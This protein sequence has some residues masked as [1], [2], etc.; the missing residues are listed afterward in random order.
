MTEARR[1]GR[2]GALVA[3]VVTILGLHLITPR[4]D[5]DQAVTGLMGWH[6]LQGEFPIFF[7]SQ[8]H[9]GV[10]EAY[11]A[12]VTF[13]LF[14]LSRAA[15][16]LVPALAALGLVLLVYRTGALLFGH[17]AG[18][19]GMLFATIVSPYVAAHY[20]RARAYYV[21]HLLLGQV[22]LCAAALWLVR[23]RGPSPL[24]QA[25]RT[26]LLVVMGLAGGL[27]LYCGF[28]IVD[29]LIPALLV[30]LLTDPRLPLRPGAWLGVLAFLVGSLPFWLYN[31][32]HDWATFVVGQRFQAATSTAEA[33]RHL[34]AQLLPILLG[35]KPW[36]DTPPF[37]PWPLALVVPVTAA[38]AVLWL[39]LRA[40]TALPRIGR[41]PERAGEAFLVVAAA[42]AVGVVWYG[43]YIQVPRYL[44]PLSPVLALVLARFVQL[45]GRRSRLVAAI[46]ALAYLGVVGVGMVGDVTIL[47]P[48]QWAAYWGERREDDRLFAFLREQGITHAYSF[49]YWLAPRLTF[50]AGERPVVAQPFSDRYPPYTRAV[51]D[52][53]R[54]AYILRVDAERVARWLRG[55]EATARRQDVG[56]YTVFWDF[57]APPAAVALP[58]AGWRL[59]TTAGRGEAAEL[60]DGQLHSGWASA[61]GPAG[62][63]SV[64]VD[65]GQ[66]A[67][68]SGVTVISTRP[69]HGPDHL[70]VAA[71]LGRGT[72]DP[73][74][75]IEVGGL[76]VVWQNGALRAAPGRTLTVR[77]PPVR[78]RR[79]SLTDLGPGGTWSVGELFL[80]GPPGLRPRPATAD[81]VATVESL[82]AEGRRLERAGN[83]AAALGRYRLAM[84]RGPDVPDGYAEFARLGADVP[85]RAGSAAAQAAWFAEAGLVEEARDRYSAIAAS[86][87]ADRLDAD[88]ARR[89]AALAVQAGDRPEATRLLAEA[90]RVETPTHRV[91][92]V[93]GRVV[94][95]VG[96]DL[97]SETLRAG[98]T[99]ELGYHWRFHGQTREPLSAYVHFRIGGGRTR[100]E[101]DH[102]LPAPVPGF[103]IPQSVLERRWVTI[104]ADAEPGR[105]RLV[106]GVWNPQTGGRLRRWW[107]GLVP[108]LETTVELGTVEIQPRS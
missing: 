70:Q 51:D 92:A 61:R 17:G 25:A 45:V 63:A 73:V 105:Y 87:G 83:V 93:M 7:W 42:V 27:G 57:G 84:R 95:L 28:Q 22:V 1:D 68:V 11:G 4:L 75:D 10:P 50:D 100:F 21:E 107:R 6:V 69:Q 15:L 108:T 82:V 97:G 46:V 26:R 79:L 47:S 71:D 31:L 54:P 18:L 49:E 38:A 88:L 59:H 78:T 37:V 104:P 52:S 29:A 34:F 89:R 12:A 48:S 35:V 14:G 40:L 86:L 16:S 19:L 30:V 5:S 55:I 65:L 98:D 62:S 24:G 102:P 91:G 103:P 77:F 56:P 39:A 33:G 101:D 67:T 85:V 76:A 74:G 99:I 2:F 53:P 23:G 32:T 20:E 41:S 3:L 60:V 44:L 72:L 94:E 66:P 58:R 96:W 106:A 64:L 80:L 43:R 90:A 81:Q 9:A 36:I 8:H 13:F